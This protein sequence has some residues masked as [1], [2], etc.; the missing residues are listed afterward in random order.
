[1]W[2]LSQTFIFFFLLC[3][4]V[5]DNRSGVGIG[6][7]EQECEGVLFRESDYCTISDNWTVEVSPRPSKVCFSTKVSSGNSRL[8]AMSLRIM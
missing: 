6:W 5:T 3:A 7:D 4:T 8:S 2:P 1:M